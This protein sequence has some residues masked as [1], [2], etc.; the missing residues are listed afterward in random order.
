[1]LR[2]VFSGSVK[3]QYEFT[4]KKVKNINLRVKSDGTVTVSA[5]RGVPVS[6]VD[7][8]VSS[9]ADF[10]L[11]ARDKLEKPANPYRTAEET[12]AAIHNLCNAAYPY[13][14]NYLPEP[15]TVKFRRMRSRW[16]SCC[17]QKNILTF[18]IYL[19]YAPA[20]CVEY[21]V[22]HEFTHFIHPNH[23]KQFHQE[24]AKVCPECKELR[25]KLKEIRIP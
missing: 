12:V 25:R 3:I 9:K 16:G 8:F 11:K 18:N 20:D 14:K 7:D 21:V 15:P 6:A 1:M 5:G 4:R 23:S 13:F 17:P 22:L 2:T 24:L 19:M 10:I